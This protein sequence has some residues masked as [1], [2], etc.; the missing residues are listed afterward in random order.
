MGY[1]APHYQ[2][3][4]PHGVVTTA[5]SLHRGWEMPPENVKP[6]DIVTR[7]GLF[8]PW[9]HPDLGELPPGVN[10]GKVEPWGLSSFQ[11]FPN[12]AILIWEAGWYNTHQFW[13]TSHNSLVFEG[14]VF[15]LPSKSASE[16]VGRE[17]AA[18]SFKEYS[19]Q[20]AN[21]L[22]ATQMGL[23]ARV[24]DRF[25]L[26]DQ[27]VLV[28]NFHQVVGDWVS[29]YELEQMK[30]VSGEWRCFRAEFSEL[31]PFAAKW[32]LATEPERWATR[33]SSSMAELQAFYDA[34]FPRVTDAHRVLRHVPV[35]R[36]AR[37]RGQ[38]LA[39]GVLVRDRVVRGRAVESTRR[40]RHTR[41]VLRPRRRAASM[42]TRE[43]NELMTRVEGDAP[44][45]R[46]MRDNY[47]I[48]FAMS[49]HLVHGDAPMPVRLVRRQL[50]RVPRRRRPHRFPRRAVPAPPL[51]AA[52]RA[53][54]G[55]R[56]PLHLP[57][58]EDRRLGLRRRVPEPGPPTRAV[59]RQRARRPLPR[60]R[61]RRP[62]V[63]VARRRRDATLPRSAV[64]RRRSVPLLVRVA[65]P[66]Q[67]A[68]GPR[69]LRRLRPRRDAPP[70]AG[71][72]SPSTWRSTPTSATRSPRRRRPTRPSPPRTAC[73]RRRCGRPPTVEPTCAS[74]ST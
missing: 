55:Q 71:S 34:I 26:N 23:E 65:G 69:G 5:G 14:N 74:R 72:P 47:W 46:L 58:V 32:C 37:R 31:E 12:F 4:G 42:T 30:G 66:L 41:H 62:R 59:R 20:D 40:S 61:G 64:R 45:G 13:P 35:R 73:G 48:P 51:L 29:D 2:I 52:P 11:F 19:L 44:M 63:G 70:D 68:P 21:T 22:E 15:S 49:A 9:E 7:S 57:R 50:R 3:D 54:R 10:P 33:M 8:G 43:E 17:M 28:R 60:P 53:H 56:R 39:A 6:S 18:V 36:H 27:E 25:P 67:L 16:R 1:E 24:V 38:P